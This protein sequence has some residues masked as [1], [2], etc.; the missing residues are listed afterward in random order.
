MGWRKTRPGRLVVGV[1]NLSLPFT[2]KQRRL[3]Q[4]HVLNSTGTHKLVCSPDTDVYHIGLP[5]VC[6]RA[7]DVFVRISI[8]SSQENCYI[9]LNNL[10]ACLQ[11]DP[12]LSS[13]PQQV[14][15][16]VL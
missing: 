10:S 15:P 11:S 9:S 13:V 4:V 8:F 2:V 16:S 5:L 1:Y 7:L 6:N 3:I 12:D 14:L